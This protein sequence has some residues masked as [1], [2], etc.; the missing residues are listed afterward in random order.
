MPQIQRFSP[1]DEQLHILA[2]QFDCSASYAPNL[3]IFYQILQA[4]FL[5]TS[6]FPSSGTSEI[7]QNTYPKFSGANFQIGFSVAGAGWRRSA[8]GRGLICEKVFE[9]LKNIPLK[10]SSTPKTFKTPS[11]KNHKTV[12]V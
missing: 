2:P 1:S 10:N 4:D 12:F 11:P 9:K 5:A 6:I 8:A 3:G 7:P